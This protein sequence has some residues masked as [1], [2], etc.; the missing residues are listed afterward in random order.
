M[1]VFEQGSRGESGWDADPVLSLDVFTVLA[2]QIQF[3]RPDKFKSYHVS[4]WESPSFSPI[5]LLP[6]MSLDEADLQ[7]IE[8]FFC[9]HPIQ[10][11]ALNPA[12]YFNFFR[13]GGN[14]DEAVRFKLAEHGWQIDPDPLSIEF[15]DLGASSPS[16][17]GL[18]LQV[19]DAASGLHPEYRELLAHEFA[20]DERYLDAVERVY[21][22]SPARSYTVL[23]GPAGGAATAGGTVS[24]RGDTAFMSWGCVSARCQ[25]RG[26]HRLLVSGCAAV[27]DER[28]ARV[29]A[30]TTR[31]A[32]IR[33]RWS[34]YLEL[35]ICRKTGEGKVV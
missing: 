7:D 35:W 34:R 22:R 33:K 24:V 27:A 26:L 31:N 6:G 14:E 15:V 3:L 10:N 4:G 32:R 12:P 25:N 23:V 1:S 11:P 28:G 13:A 30:F 20:G 16:I 8:Q 2:N 17:P 9:T 29:C 5:I 19:L 18:K 21:R